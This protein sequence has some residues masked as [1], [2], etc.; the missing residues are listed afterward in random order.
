[1]YR[2]SNDPRILVDM[3]LA[4]TNSEDVRG[5]APE[6]EEF[7]KKSPNDPFLN[8]AW[9][10]ALL[11]KGRGAE[12]LPFL[13]RAAE[14]LENDPVGRFALAECRMAKGES[15]H[16]LSALGTVPSD[17]ADAARWWVLRSR[18]EEAWGEPEAALASL[19]AAIAAN[20]DSREAHFRYGQALARRGE[21]AAGKEHTDRAEFLRRRELALRRAHERVKREAL[22]PE[23]CERRA[24]LCA[25]S[26]LTAEARAWL[27]QAISIDP[28]RSAAQTELARLPK[29]PKPLPYALARPVLAASAH[30]TTTAQP[31]PVDRAGPPAETLP[32]LEDL[33]QKT[34]LART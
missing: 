26:D 2:I 32:H 6:L 25:E 18:L 19:K 24:R 20:P 8:R 34:G 28:T 11:L 10:L 30:R 9:G 13:A 14:T 21:A 29:E 16:E 31:R 12:A 27:Q 7:L 22:T 1:M 15:V 33:A 4:P 5:L 23:V 3:V 17:P